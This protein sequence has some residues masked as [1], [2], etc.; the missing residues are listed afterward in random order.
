MGDPAGEFSGV[1]WFI[2]IIA[3]VA[4]LLPNIFYTL[5]L[6]RSFTA[7]DPPL[8]PIAPGL[9]WLFLIPV[10]NFGW[11]FFLV[12]YLKRGYDRMAAAG[13]LSAPT[14]AGFGVGIGFAVCF[15]LTL[16]PAI[17]V[18]AVIPMLVLWVLHW[19]QA[20]AARKLVLPNAS[21]VGSP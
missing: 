13:R 11:S 9:V 15:A 4:V 16:V 8:R 7:I 21:A 20:A 1:H 6:Q 10:F 5:T 17:N 12:V 14:S 2:V 18:L 19:V 3:I